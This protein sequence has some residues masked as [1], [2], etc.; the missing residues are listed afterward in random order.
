[1]KN[2]TAHH[3]PLKQH[4]IIKN[5]G[6]RAERAAQQLVKEHK[7]QII[8]LNYQCRF[9]EIDIITQHNH[10][11]VFIEVRQRS[12]QQWGG[13]I[14][15]ITRS[16]QSKIIR[17]ANYFMGKNPHLAYLNARFDVICF[18]DT[19]DVTLATWI[20]HAFMEGE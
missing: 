11:M 2:T 7:H 14:H 10:T 13:A 17:C 20:E 19:F 12:K 1:M 6:L 4:A 3:H 8:K 5:N 18:E 9:G 15:S 16:K